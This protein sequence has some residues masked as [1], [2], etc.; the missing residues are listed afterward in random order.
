VKVWADVH[1]AA[2]KLGWKTQRNLKQML[3]DAWN[4]QKMLGEQKH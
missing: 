2:E 3:A 4:W 1:K